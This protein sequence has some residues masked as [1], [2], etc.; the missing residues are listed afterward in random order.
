MHI[1]NASSRA[2]CWRNGMTS[3]YLSGVL[4]VTLSFAL[5]MPAEAQSSSGKIVSD[6]TIAGGI[7]GAVAAV[8]VV[9]I[10]AIHYSKK[11]MITGCV[12]SAGNGLTVIDEKDRQTYALSGDTTAIKLGDR[13]RLQGKKVKSMLSGAPLGW[14]IK[15][16]VKDLG[17][18]QP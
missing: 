16:V 10:V 9:A 15:T 17:V 1:H 11:R 14:E 8:A 5:C 6:G 4:I 3:Q 18:C 7:V 13:V 2:D 12:K